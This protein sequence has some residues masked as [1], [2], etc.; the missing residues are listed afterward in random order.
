MIEL[1]INH[2][3]PLQKKNDLKIDLQL[4]MLGITMIY[5]RSGAGKTTLLRCISGIEKPNSARISIGSE[6]LID[7]EQGI[8]IPP[9]Q[10]NIGYLLQGQQ[11]FPH[12]TVRK[13]LEYAVKRVKKAKIHHHSLIHLAEVISF[14]EL[15]SLLMKYPSQL[16]GGEQ[17]RVAIARILLSNPRLI[18]L[19]EALNALDNLIQEKLLSYIVQIQEIYKIP[20][21]FVTHSLKD[22]VKAANFVVIL[23]NGQVA[24]KGDFRTIIHK[25]AFIELAG[26]T[27][28][29]EGK[30]LGHNTERQQSLI[31]WNNTIL[32]I[33]HITAA[34]GSNIRLWLISQTDEN[35]A[36]Q[37]D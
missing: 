18:L 9:H 31:S 34:E 2:S 33:P 30:I 15:Q 10:R 17:Q 5:G 35:K 29:L 36:T 28:L 26:N 7:T 4:P 25:K 27:Q 8:E 11:L 22:L 6:L 14:L 12:L 23:K 13:N 24:A 16:S 37:L 1:K 32:T 3:Y 20:I 21:I 19:D